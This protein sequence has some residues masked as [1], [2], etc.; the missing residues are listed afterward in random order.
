MVPQRA[1]YGGLHALRSGD[2][3]LLELS[4][5]I[6][7]AI[8]VIPLLLPANYYNLS[9]IVDSQGAILHKPFCEFDSSTYNYR[10][11]H[12]PLTEIGPRA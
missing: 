10:T 12:M 7:V 11:P 8:L 2:L 5:R 9:R 3:S 1:Q 6:A 4:L